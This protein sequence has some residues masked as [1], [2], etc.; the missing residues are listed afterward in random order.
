MHLELCIMFFLS[1]CLV[2]TCLRG[3]RENMQM[4]TTQKQLSP[5]LRIKPRP[6]S[7]SVG[8]RPWEDRMSEFVPNL[9]EKLLVCVCVVCVC[10][11]CVATGWWCQSF[12]ACFTGAVSAPALYCCRTAAEWWVSVL[13]LHRLVIFAWIRPPVITSSCVYWHMFNFAVT[14]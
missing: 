14:V 1:V 7:D 13:F 11:A 4:R 10:L 8:T 6:L 9:N 5:D 2:F 12:V 3:D